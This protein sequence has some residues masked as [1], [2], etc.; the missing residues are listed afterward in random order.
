MWFLIMNKAA[1]HDNKSLKTFYLYAAV[2]LIL[3]CLSL[4]IKLIYIYQQSRFDPAHD[5]ILAVV[6]QKSVKEIIAFH[7]QTPAFSL[8]LIQENGIPYDQ[9]AKQYGIATDGYIVM[10]AG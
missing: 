1:Q 9:L 2:V 3:I 8:L 5:F 6:Q 4:L 7:P 10:Q